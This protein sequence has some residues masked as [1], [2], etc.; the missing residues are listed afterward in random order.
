MT[1]RTRR[2]G[3][4][5]VSLAALVLAACSNGGA[6][7]DGGMDAGFVGWSEGGVDAPFDSPDTG[8]LSDPEIVG[9]LHAIHQG[10]IQIADFAATHARTAPVIAFAN[11]IGAQH[12]AADA[13]LSD[14]ASVAGLTS[15]DTSVSIRQANLRTYKLDELM[16]AGCATLDSLYVGDVWAIQDSI[17]LIDDHLLPAVS[18]AAIRTELESTRAI[19][20]MQLDGLPRPD[21]SMPDAS[22]P[23]WEAG[24]F[25][26]TGCA[27]VDAYFDVGPD[28]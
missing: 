22:T 26:D 12:A 18:S 4:R 14:A 1:T 19:L 8:P 9:V 11:G 21:G 25:D 15:V 2:G 13:S 6:T 24:P 28:S 17:G 16:S 20:T 5:I 23:N 10:E 27:P 3:R 7:S